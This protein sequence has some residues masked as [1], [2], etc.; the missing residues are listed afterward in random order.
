[1]GWKDI[2]VFTFIIFFS[3]QG[4][5][6]L[7]PL[8]FFFFFFDYHNALKRTAGSAQ[9]GAVAQTNTHTRW[10]EMDA[11]VSSTL[12]QT[13]YVRHPNISSFT[14][15]HTHCGRFLFFSFQHKPLSLFLINLIASCPFS[16]NTTASRN[17]LISAEDSRPPGDF[18]LDGLW[19]SLGLGS[20]L[21]RTRIITHTITNFALWDGGLAVCFFNLFLKG[22]KVRV[23]IIIGDSES[24]LCALFLSGGPSTFGG[25]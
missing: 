11:H 13:I 10:F 21:T 24:I 1:M 8:I 23:S 2:L 15:A 18:Y 4:L 6:T 25:I 9:G 7:S 12:S 5:L 14:A 22:G 16:F 3:S 17:F 19:E 20:Q